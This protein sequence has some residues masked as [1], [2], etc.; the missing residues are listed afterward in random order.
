V[1]R[2][3]H[4][5]VSVKNCRG[6]RSC[7]LVCSFSKVGVFNPAK[8]MIRLERDVET[9]HT[10]PMICPIGCDLCGGDPACVRACRYGCIT[11]GSEAVDYK[12]LVR[13]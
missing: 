4:L 8:S 7:Q 1:E 10:A 12:I 6:C 9:D 2:A 13:M 5:V 11:S 3:D